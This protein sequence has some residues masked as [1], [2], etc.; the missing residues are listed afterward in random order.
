VRALELAHEPGAPIAKPCG[1]VARALD[2]SVQR[3]VAGNLS[4]LNIGLSEHMQPL[5]R[6]R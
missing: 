1:K 4:S 5:G 2:A 3:R 6:R